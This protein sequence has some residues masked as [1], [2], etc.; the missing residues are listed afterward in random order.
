MA[1]FISNGWEI[2]FHPQL[3][4]TQY[5]ELINR[6]ANLREQVTRSRV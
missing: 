4:G 3:F 1:K 5:Q 6:V 2:F